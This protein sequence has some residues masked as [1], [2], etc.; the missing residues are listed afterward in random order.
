M[1]ATIINLPL[2]PSPE[3]PPSN[4]TFNTPPAAPSIAH[5][6]AWRDSRLRPIRDLRL[7]ITDRCNLRC[8]YC[9]DPDHRY[10]PAASL[11]SADQLLRAARAC[12]D[13]GVSSIRITGGEPTLHPEI[14]NIIQRLAHLPID[15]LA[16][17]TNGVLIDRAAL[18][19]WRALGLARITFSLDTL[20]A[21]R[22]ADL[23]RVRFDPQRVLDVIA[24]AQSLNLAPVKLN[25]VI[26][27]GVNDDELVDFANLART[28]N[29]DVRFIEFM[30]LDSGRTWRRAAVV[31]AAEMKQ[32]IADAHPIVPLGRDDPHAPSTAY[33]FADHAPGRL[34]FIAPVTERFC[35]QCTRIRLTADGKI[36]TCLF[37]DREWDIA[38]RL[39]GDDDALRRFL[40]DA[41]WTKPRGHDIDSPAFTPPPR[42][43]SAIGG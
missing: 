41:A 36:R 26:M 28:M 24:D 43:M 33:R 19:R 31:G 27:R 10:L 12:V 39:A 8:A 29:L 3:A 21:D 4:S 35:D 1:A 9:M 40:I 6:G 30:P 16:M 18:D 7:S 11:L 17:T 34:G 13:L 42:G 2:L 15:D 23:T 38:P 25:V 20:R 32:R 22:F 37:S 14:N 5:T